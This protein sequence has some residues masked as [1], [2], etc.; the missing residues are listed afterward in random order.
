MLPRPQLGT[1]NADD[2][3]IQLL[4]DG[5]NARVTQIAILLVHQ[6]VQPIG[7]SFQAL[8]NIVIRHTLTSF[9]ALSN[10]FLLKTVY[11]EWKMDN[12]MHLTFAE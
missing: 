1:L 6:T 4:A 10:P 7:E 9:V 2:Q 11:D 8:V 12:V 3:S 5:N